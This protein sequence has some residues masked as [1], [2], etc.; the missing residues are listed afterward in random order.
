MIVLAGRLVLITSSATCVVLATPSALRP[1]NTK[2]Y[3][4]SVCL[5]AVQMIQMLVGI[6][7][8]GTWAYFHKIEGAESCPCDSP[9][10]AIGAGTVMYGSYFYLFLMFYLNRY[11]KKPSAEKKKQ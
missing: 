11:I 8:T 2:C 10:V 1:L 5:P 7:V 4:L 6:A 9:D 3:Q